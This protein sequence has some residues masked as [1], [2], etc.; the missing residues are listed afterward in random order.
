VRALN[1]L[2]E[3]YW[4]ENSN[5]NALKVVENQVALRP[6]SK[7]LQLALGNWYVRAG[8]RQQAREAF[9]R[10][11][12]GDPGAV[13][14][15]LALAQLE[16]SQGRWNEAQSAL[17][18]VLQLQSSNVNARLLQALLAESRRDRST[19]VREYQQILSLQ[20]DNVVALNNLAYRFATDHQEFDTALKYAQRA[21]EIEPDNPNVDDTL[22]WIFY[23]KGV[24]RSG[25]R[26]LE[27]AV[28]KQQKNPTF[29]YHLAMVHLRIGNIDEGRRALGVALTLNPNLPEATLAQ[30][31]LKEETPTP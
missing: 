15:R 12:A 20:P 1:L 26:Y 28:A 6:D 24:P 17:D 4:R 16:I 8:S 29:L 11:A 5:Q 10:A 9:Q 31:V 25:L 7:E 3:T 13:D 23:L 14:A 27:S 19:A 21:K 22:G 2:A 30:Q 18:Q